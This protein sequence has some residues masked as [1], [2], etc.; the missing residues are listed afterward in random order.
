[1][2]ALAFANTVEACGGQGEELVFVQYARSERKNVLVIGGEAFEDPEVVGVAFA[3]ELVGQ[4]G[5]GTK[6]LHQPGMEVFV[7]EDGEEILIVFGTGG[8]AGAGKD[9]CVCLK[10]AGGFVFQTAIETGADL[11]V[12]QILTEGGGAPEVEDGFQN[13]LCILQDEV[14]VESG[15][16]GAGE[17]ERVGNAA[18]GEVE[19]AV[20]AL[21]R[22]EGD[23]GVEKLLGAGGCKTVRAD[24]FKA[25]VGNKAAVGKVEKAGSVDAFGDQKHGC[26][27]VEAADVVEPGVVNACRISEGFPFDA[28]GGAGCQTRDG[29]VALVRLEE[30]ACAGAGAADAACVVANEIAAACPG[31]HVKRNGVL[32]RRQLER[33]AQQVGVRIRC[34]CIAEHEGPSKTF[35]DES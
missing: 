18:N 29:P 26:R 35:F 33:D 17:D 25:A 7:S 31:R 34:D 5:C 27:I 10:H 23:G 19:N 30:R 12:K 4:E 9:Q 21:C 11:D 28:K 3:L 8:F 1:V 13:G 16:A 15:G 32:R 2:E 6:M 20:F 14:L 24:G 22:R